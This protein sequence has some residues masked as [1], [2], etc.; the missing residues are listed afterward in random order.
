MD[1]TAVIFLIGPF[2]LGF[3]LGN[4][5]D[6]FTKLFKNGSAMLFPIVGL[7]FGYLCAEIIPEYQ[8]YLSSAI[9]QI[10]ICMLVTTFLTPFLT[11]YIVQ[12]FKTKKLDKQKALSKD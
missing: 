3:L 9:S 6:E 1:I 10:S 5:D 8:I 4:L 2:L 7:Q 12:K 11:K